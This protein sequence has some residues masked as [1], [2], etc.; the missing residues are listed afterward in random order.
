[1]ATRRVQPGDADPVAFPD[2]PYPASHGHD[3]PHALVA[4]DEWRVR[5]HRPVALGGVQVGVAYATGLDPDQYL[6]RPRAR[7][8][9]FLDHQWFAELTHDSGL[10]GWIHVR[11]SVVRLPTE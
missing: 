10:H 2:V 1:M 7:Y 8:R 5:F 9:D 11:I 3:V 6:A 4:G